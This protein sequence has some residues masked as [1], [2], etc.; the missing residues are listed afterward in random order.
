MV[1]GP[2]A[3]I[4]RK[5]DGVPNANEDADLRQ[6]ILA[7]QPIDIALIFL[8]L[9]GKVQDDLLRDR[10]LCVKLVGLTS[11]ADAPIA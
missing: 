3:T 7:P 8:N 6:C 2:S 9:S 10:P 1:G 11:H 4:E 5:V